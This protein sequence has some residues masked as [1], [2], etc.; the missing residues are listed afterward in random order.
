MGLHPR[1]LAGGREEATDFAPGHVLSE[2]HLVAGNGREFGAGRPVQG[3]RP[4]IAENEGSRS[5]DTAF[6]D[7]DVVAQGG[8]HSDKAFGPDPNTA[9]DNHM[10]GNEAVILDRRMMADVITRPERDVV[11]DFDEGLDGV[12][13]ENETVVADRFAGEHGGAGAAIG[14]ESVALLPGFCDLGG[15]QLVKLVVTYGD[16]QVMGGRRESFRHLIEGHDGQPAEGVGGLERGVHG[17]AGER[18][19]R[20]SGEIEMGELANIAAAENNEWFHGSRVL[21]HE[22]GEFI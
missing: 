7:G 4:D 21:A 12:V 20:V 11:T 15:A 17:E 1:L 22:E 13:L 19:V 3:V 2:R 16:K 5:D 8:V 6:T 14:D 18:P 10:G 9:R